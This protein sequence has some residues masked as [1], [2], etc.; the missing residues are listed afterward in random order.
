MKKSVSFVLALLCVLSMNLNA[1]AINENAEIL[2]NESILLE[3]NA[4]ES[5]PQTAGLS[6]AADGESG[7]PLSGLLAPNQS[8][9]FPILIS[10]ANGNPVPLT[11]AHL[12]ETRLRVETKDGRSAVRSIKVVEDDN[13]YALQ[14]NTLSGYPSKITD[15]SGQLKLVKKTTGAVVHSLDLNFSVGYGRLSEETIAGVENGQYIYLDNDTPV[16]T[17]E[18]FEKIDRLAKGEKVILT[19]GRWAYEVRVTEQ[20]SVNLIHDEKPI[21]EILTQFEDQ[22]FQFLNFPAGPAFDFTGTLTIDVSDAA[23][24]FDNLYL[25]SYYNG[26]LNKVY[27]SYNEEEQTLSF[28]TKY[29]GRFVITD[30]EI[31][32]GTVVNCD[33]TVG[34]NNNGSGSVSTKP[35]PNTGAAQLPVRLAASMATLS[36]AVLSFFGFRKNQK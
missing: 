7:L 2:N 18:Q 35:N 8:L 9:R 10:D 11:D 17:A 19:N 22:D 34:S 21:K 1:F 28:K 25:Y 36:A 16:I 3:E 15:Y 12:E 26:K 13:G 30:K 14:V 29:F 33:D 23:E 6:L 4:E 5:A 20:D 24:S 31:P 27:A 32:N